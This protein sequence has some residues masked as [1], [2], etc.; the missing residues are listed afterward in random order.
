MLNLTLSIHF[1]QTERRWASKVIRG[2]AKKGTLPR[3]EDY[4]EA[5]RARLVSGL[6]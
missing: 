3:R 5:I 2:E 1:D 4:E 6:Q